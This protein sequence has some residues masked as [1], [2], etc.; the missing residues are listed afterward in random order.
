VIQR[1]TSEEDANVVRHQT[2]GGDPNA[3]AIMGFAQYL[4]ERETVCDPFEQRQLPDAPIQYVIRQSTSCKS[5]SSWHQAF[6]LIPDCAV[7]IDRKR[8]A[9]PFR[10]EADGI[11]PSSRHRSA[12]D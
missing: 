3:C 6:A 9:Q 1:I 10:N 11:L 7:A 12:V 4:L 2:I 5:R 8:E